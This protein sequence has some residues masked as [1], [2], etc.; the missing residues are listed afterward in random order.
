MTPKKRKKRRAAL[1]ARNAKVTTTVKPQIQT[2][3]QAPIPNALTMKKETEIVEVET[4]PET[5]PVVNEVGANAEKPNV[6]PDVTP[7]LTKKT[8]R[9]KTTRK[10]T[11]SKK[12]T[13]SRRN[14][15]SKS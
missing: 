8:T 2:E 11:T 5:T 10:S 14:N 13:N 3:R 6:S 4:P 7:I 12:T 9:K 1:R 15:T